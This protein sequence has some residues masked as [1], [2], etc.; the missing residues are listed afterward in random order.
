[1]SNYKTKKQQRNR[2]HKRLRQKVAGTAE[3][4]RLAVCCTSKHF[5]AQFIDDDSSTT[6]ASVSTLDKG[7]VKEGLKANVEGAGKLGKM[8]AEKA[9]AAKIKK[10]VFDRGGFR[11]HGRIKAFAD[12]VREAGIAF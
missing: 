6:L 4:P 8:A 5:Y 7:F 11:Y 3:C 10:V 2:R 9:S 12:S 1:M